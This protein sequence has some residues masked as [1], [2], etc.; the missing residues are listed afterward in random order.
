[1]TKIAQFPEKVKDHRIRDLS[2]FP[3]DFRTAAEPLFKML[4]NRLQRLDDANSK[5]IPYILED[6]QL[7]SDGITNLEALMSTLC[8]MYSDLGET[9]LFLKHQ[10]RGASEIMVMLKGALYKSKLELREMKASIGHGKT[11]EDESTK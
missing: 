9:C 8:E 2:H 7:L 4:N 3:T 1:M 11:F 6:I 5:N 10:W